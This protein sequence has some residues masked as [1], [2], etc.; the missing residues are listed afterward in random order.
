MSHQI[1]L[2]N[3]DFYPRRQPFAAKML[4]QGMVLLAIAG[5]SY[6]TYVHHRVLVQEHHLAENEKQLV[7]QRERLA[8]LIN[9]IGRQSGN[10]LLESEVTRLEVKLSAKQEIA[11]LLQTG[12][13][14]SPHGFSAYMR[15]FA[16]QLLNGL[17]LT[18]FTITNKEME[19]T[20]RLIE[21]DL[22]PA[23]LQRLKD[24]AVMQGRSFSALQINL[25]APETDDSESRP[26]YLEF[27]LSSAV[28]ENKQ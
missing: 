5:V 20:G 22:M 7:L 23:Y 13:L 12:V 28:I 17:W 2:F 25:P 10:T 14:G 11:N 18:G 21:A 6:Y 1:N 15:A 9:E 27:S 19:L 24:E 8:Q 3:P 16:R 4:L 26:D